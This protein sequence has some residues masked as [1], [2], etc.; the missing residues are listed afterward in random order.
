MKQLSSNLNATLR[1]VLGV[2]IFLLLIYHVDFTVFSSLSTEQIVL[3]TLAI[4]A[5]VGTTLIEAARLRVLC[6]FDISLGEV[7]RIVFVAFFFTNLLPSSFGGD[8][9]KVLKIGKNY[10]YTKATALVLIERVLG[11][12]TLII[13]S[14]VLTILL[15]GDW[16]KDY[17]AL[18]NEVNIDLDLTQYATWTITILLLATMAVIFLF[19]RLLLRL[20]RDFHEALTG[21]P[22]SRIVYV[23]LCS[24]VLHTSRSVLLCL[25]LATVGFELSLPQAWVVI[26]FVSIASMIPLSIGGLGI[27]EAAFVLALQPFAIVSSWVLYAGLV[28]RL[29]T[30]SQ[31]AVGAFLLVRERRRDPTGV[32]I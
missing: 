30:I 4:I 16:I 25:I 7:A 20:I 21:L 29:G 5:L 31:A 9:Y 28:F 11:L 23:L 26:T 3:A 2:A 22:F 10:S 24:T 13:G 18:R 12:L 8:G 27:R 15:G 19:R 1:L 17:L 14:L 32:D 6:P